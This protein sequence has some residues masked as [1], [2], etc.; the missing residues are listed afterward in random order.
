MIVGPAR[1]GQSRR[2][3]RRLRAVA[4]AGDAAAAV[5]RP[6]PGS[7]SAGAAARRARL[8]PR[9]AG[10]RRARELLREL[11]H[12]GNTI[13]ISYAT[14]CPSSRSCAPRSPSSTREGSRRRGRN[15]SRARFGSGPR[16]S[17]ALA[18]GGGAGGRRACS[19]S[20]R[21]WPGTPR[22]RPMEL[23]LR[24]DD[25]ATA[26]LLADGA[27]GHPMVASSR[28]ERPRGA[29]PP[30]HRGAGA[31]RDEASVMTAS[32][33][34]V[35][36]PAPVRRLPR[37]AAPSRP[38]ARRRSPVS[39]AGACG[40]AGPSWW[41]RWF[42][43]LLGLLVF[44]IPRL[45]SVSSAAAN[46]DAPSDPD[47]GW[48]APSFDGDVRGGPGWVRRRFVSNRCSRSPARCWVM[49]TILVMLVAPALASSTISSSA[50]SRRWSC[51]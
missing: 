12:L 14:S 28:R 31:H 25:G 5:P 13:V 22:G 49:L 26:G 19:P 2:A 8:R 37:A 42:V 11:R 33:T 39:C 41:P 46:W 17:R 43:L 6:C 15:P 21:R 23:G 47:S 48:G 40:A 7:R 16:W 27:A 35:S 45:R 4:V 36:A 9:P 24:G 44:Q 34:T 51:W 32:T 3:A 38:P 50:R 10:P 30:R 20:T 29:V 18:G 1:P